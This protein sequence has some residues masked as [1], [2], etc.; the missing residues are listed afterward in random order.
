[1]SKFPKFIAGTALATLI[2]APAVADVYGLGR[3]ALA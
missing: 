3:E 1:M 2:A